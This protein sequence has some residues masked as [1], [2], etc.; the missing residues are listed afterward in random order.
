MIEP[1]RTFGAG[2]ESHGA[3]FSNAGR[4]FLV[5]AAAI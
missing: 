4:D 2:S 1:V 3:R 5:S